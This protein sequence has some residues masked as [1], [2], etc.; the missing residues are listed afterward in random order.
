MALYIVLAIGADDIFVFMDAY[1]QALQIPEAVVSLEARM[2]WTY[3]RAASAMLITSFTTMAA[4]V[5]SAFSPLA[6]IRSF[7]VYCAFVIFFDFCLVITW[8]PSMVVFYHNYYEDSFW[9]DPCPM[10]SKEVAG[11]KGRQSSTE[12]AREKLSAGKT[13]PR[14]KL[15]VMV[16]DSLGMFVIKKKAL[17]VAACLALS[18]PAIYLTSTVEP[19]SK[20]EEFLPSDHPFQRVFTIIGDSFGTSAE[21]GVSYVS[22]VWGFGDGREDSSSNW[23]DRSGVKLL[24]DSQNL[25]KVIPDPN[26]EFDGDCQKHIF[27]VCEEARTLDFSRGHGTMRR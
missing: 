25:G 21:D 4:F 22:V 20:T 3:S 9:C 15:E 16:G 12:K 27:D 11:E 1:K 24:W 18:I 5:S 8:F 19:S 26:F 23:V 17:L 6:Q 7:G 2:A 10:G 13:V 14:R